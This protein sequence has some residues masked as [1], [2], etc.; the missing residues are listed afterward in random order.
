MKIE[1][2]KAKSSVEFTVAFDKNDLETARLKALERL[3]RNVKIDGF[4]NGKAPANIVE[5]HVDP[6]ELASSTLDIA[7]RT[8]I[9][10]LFE[11][12]DMMPISVPHVD[13]IKYVPG[14]MAEL[15]V[16]ADIMPEVKLGNYKKLV[17]TYDA[18]AIEEKDIDD[19]LNRIAENFAEVKVVKR[20]A[21]MGDEV[22]IDFTGKKDGVAF[23]GGS[24][25]DYKLRLGSGQFIPGFE[26]GLEGFAAGDKTDLKISF[27]KDYHVKDLAGQPVV[28]E[29]LVKQVNEVEKPALDDKLAEKTGAFKTIKELRDDIRKNLEAQYG[30]G[31][32]DRFKDELLA[33]LIDSSETEAPATLVE[34]QFE[35]MKNDVMRN[36]HTQGANIEQYLESRKQKLEE[37]EEEVRQSAKRRVLGS[38]IVQKLA[39]ELGI[40]VSDAEAEEQVAEMKEVYKKDKQALA[41]LDDPQ[42]KANIRNRI[43]IDRTMDELAA[44]N[45]PH[46]KKSEKKSEKKTDA[47]K[48]TKK[49]SKKSDK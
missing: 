29:V 21:K 32:E 33:A 18:P 40:E 27:P 13:I 5:Q 1:S 25:K 4:R 41:Q 35:N 37:W 11:G 38:I 24:A 48:S 20:A 8:A 9:P 2:K 46:A 39:D 12:T 31:A 26:E 30:Q 49:T 3:A 6:N 34:E 42:V 22:I 15:S 23:D 44:I 17:A 28:F 19:V 7:V 36:L 14:E 47:K 45:K 10:K 43:R 16:K